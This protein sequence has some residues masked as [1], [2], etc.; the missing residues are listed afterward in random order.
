MPVYVKIEREREREVKEKE[1][2]SERGKK[3]LYTCALM[4]HKACLFNF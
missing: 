2:E 1:R 3:L 4:H